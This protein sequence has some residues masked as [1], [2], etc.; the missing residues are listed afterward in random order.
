MHCDSHLW[1]GAENTHNNE[2][3]DWTLHMHFD[4]LLC[5]YLNMNSDSYF[6]SLTH[7]RWHRQ[8]WTTTKGGIKRSSLKLHEFVVCRFWL[9]TW[10]SSRKKERNK[11][12]SF[13]AKSI[14]KLSEIYV[15]F[16]HLKWCFVCA[17][18]ARTSEGKYEEFIFKVGQV[19]EWTSI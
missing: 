19:M 7:P 15:R 16:F 13:M 10:A 5:C 4:T 8:K 17:S 12:F 14:R 3:R 18:C 9:L 11:M 1:I 2:P 6:S